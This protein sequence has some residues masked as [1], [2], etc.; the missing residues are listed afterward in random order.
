MAWGF[1]LGLP[2]QVASAWVGVANE[3]SAAPSDTVAV[4]ALALGL[5]TAP[6]LTFG[7][8]GAL[9]GC[10]S[11][12]RVGGVA[13][14]PRPDVAHDVPAAVAVL[15]TIFGPWGLGFYQGLPYWGTVLVAVAG[16]GG[17]AGLAGLVLGRFRQGPFEWVM[18]AWTRAWARTIR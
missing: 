6:L 18:S 9:L 2:L 17:L 13:A 12:A 3:L 16:Y 15:A 5:T 4:G 10:S 7:Y 8:V 1:G 14:L 11:G